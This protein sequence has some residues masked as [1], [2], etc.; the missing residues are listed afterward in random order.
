MEETSWLF[1]VGWLAVY[2]VSVVMAVAQYE[3][4]SAQSSAAKKALVKSLPYLVSIA[5]IMYRGLE[6]KEY[7]DTGLSVITLFAVT[8]VIVWSTRKQWKAR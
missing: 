7:L 8:W 2:G 6:K 1:V 4:T 5:P 3:V